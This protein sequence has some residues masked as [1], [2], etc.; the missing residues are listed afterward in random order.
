MRILQNSIDA[1]FLGYDVFGRSF[2]PAAVIPSAAGSPPAP[3]T[4]SM[5]ASGSVDGGA[6]G[7]IES[8]RARARG[9][10]EEKEVLTPAQCRRKAQNRAA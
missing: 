9:S 10:S 2:D 8:D 5:M 3:P 4:P 7:D 6:F 1:R